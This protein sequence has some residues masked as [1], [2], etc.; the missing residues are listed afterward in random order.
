MDSASRLHLPGI[1]PNVR[2]P[3]AL[4]QIALHH[5]YNLPD[6]T[7]VFVRIRHKQLNS[8]LSDYSIILLWPLNP[9]ADKH[10]AIPATG[11]HRCH[12]MMERRMQKINSFFVLWKY[13]VKA[14]IELIRS[15][16]GLI[17]TLV[18]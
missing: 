8:P 15:L 13:V 6:Q 7:L 2:E 10:T 3:D 12:Q 17:P 5:V 1:E 4:V 18:A 11:V 9:V 16:K 14:P